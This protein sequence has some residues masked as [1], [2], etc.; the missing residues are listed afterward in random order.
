M[1]GA[2]RCDVPARALAGGANSCAGH[3]QNFGHRATG[4]SGHMLVAQT[5]PFPGHNGHEFAV[6][7]NAGGGIR[8]KGVQAKNE[9][10]IKI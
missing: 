4:K 1:V 3:A 10:E 7:Q 8:V 9:H 5:E 6:P 2:L